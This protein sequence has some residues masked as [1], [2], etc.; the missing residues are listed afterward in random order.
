MSKSGDWNNLGEDKGGWETLEGH[1]GLHPERKVGAILQG[2]N[3]LGH[4]PHRTRFPES[5]VRL[6]L[7]ARADAPRMAPT[8][9]SIG[10]N[11]AMRTNLNKDTLR[12][13]RKSTSL[14]QA[15]QRRQQVE[16]HVVLANNLQGRGR[17]QHQT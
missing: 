17:A 4:P 15:I 2:T 8:A 16:S 13:R 5:L 9:A 7:S 3:V 10:G 1:G 6:G 14:R 12:S 11:L